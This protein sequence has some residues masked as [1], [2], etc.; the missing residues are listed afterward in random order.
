[1]DESILL[2]ELGQVS[3]SEAGAVFRE[4]LRGCVREMLS[5]VM[6]AGTES[7]GH[8]RFGSFEV[9]G[10]LLKLKDWVNRWVG[11]KLAAP[12]MQVGLEEIARN[13]EVQFNDW[14]V[15]SSR[16]RGPRSQQPNI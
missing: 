4:Y 10:S 13:L 2:R 6:A 3:S 15:G 8:G 7:S 11:R 1:M 14:A 16:N 12:E 9:E 5:D